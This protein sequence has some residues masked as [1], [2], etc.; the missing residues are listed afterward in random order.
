M[1]NIYT[2]DALI[3]QPA[4]AILGKLG[5]KP[6]NCFDET[7]GAKNANLLLPRLVSGEVTVEGDESMRS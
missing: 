4:I 6:A 7:F 1:N 5:W 2:E 3:E